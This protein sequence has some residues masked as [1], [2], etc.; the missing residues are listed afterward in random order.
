MD[1]LGLFEG[2]SWTASDVEDEGGASGICTPSP[3]NTLTELARLYALVP[4]VGSC[5]WFSGANNVSSS[6]SVLPDA[7]GNAVVN[8]GLVALGLARLMFLTVKPCSL[9]GSSGGA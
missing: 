3:L 4:G 6:V 8:R 7:L 5:L 1:L 9:A 2:L